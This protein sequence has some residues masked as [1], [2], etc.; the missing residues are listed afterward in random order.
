MAT[1]N[2]FSSKINVMPI[3]VSLPVKGRIFPT[4]LLR[5][6]PRGV[7][8]PLCQP[9]GHE[10]IRATR[11]VRI[12]NYTNHLVSVTEVKSERVARSGRFD[13]GG[14]GQHTGK[15]IAAEQIRAAVLIVRAEIERQRTFLC[16][17]RF[18]PRQQSRADA[19]PLIFRSNGQRMKFPRM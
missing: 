5:T 7:C 11:T 9:L 2:F 19:A 16:R 13:R 18:G 14:G 8:P 10:N 12:G 3:F 17:A 6:P 15:Q 4:P 1:Q